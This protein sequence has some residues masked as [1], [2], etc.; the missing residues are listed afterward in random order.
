MLEAMFDG[1]AAKDFG[2]RLAA[3]VESTTYTR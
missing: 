1:A 3:F 2:L